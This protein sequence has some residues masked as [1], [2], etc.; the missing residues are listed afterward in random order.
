MAF[1]RSNHRRR[2]CEALVEP[3]VAVQEL[4]LGS[5]GCLVQ[6]LGA[7]HHAEPPTKLAVKRFCIIAHH[8][9]PAAFGG[10]FWTKCTHNHEATS[11]DQAGNLP[12]VGRTSLRCRK[13]MEYRSVMPEI[14]GILFQP[15]FDNITD[16]PTHLLCRRTQPL[17]RDFD[18][19]LRDIEYGEVFVSSKKQIVD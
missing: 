10:A 15:D 18:C 17:F 7:L 3:A 4:L 8:F 12:N 11:L 5:K 6:F 2:V 14:V 1:G 13:K 19:G 9:K 16:Q